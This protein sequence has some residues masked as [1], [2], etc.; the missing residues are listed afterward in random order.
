MRLPRATYFGRVNAWIRLY[1]TKN[2]FWMFPPLIASIAISLIY[3]LTH[4]YPA[5]SGG[6]FL[7]SGEII[8]QNNYILPS[9]IPYF[10]NGTVPFAYPPL[11]FYVVAVLRDLGFGHI[12]ITRFVPA[13]L[14]VLYII[15]A[16]YL[17]RD[18]LGGRIYGSVFA[19]I[20]AISPE[21]LLFT[22]PA[23]GI[24]R[25]W[26]MLFT[27]IGLNAGL[28]LF[29]DGGQKWLVLGGLMF[30][31][32]LMTHPVFAAFYGVSYIL[33]MINLRRTSKGLLLGIGSAGIGFLIASPWWLLVVSRHGFEVYLLGSSSQAQYLTKHPRLAVSEA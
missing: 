10:A 7:H 1:K 26:A 21:I 30:G 17:G 25:A 18:L 14:T 13:I 16:F 27:L 23:G 6:L 8:L 31:L 12:T 4:P 11:G 2:W 24:V 20:I 3:L 29:R 33:F 22:L 15:P 9:T 28:R 32:T 5:F 19:F